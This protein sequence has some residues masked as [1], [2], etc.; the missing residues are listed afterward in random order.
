MTTPT[1]ITQHR[2]VLTQA[3]AEARA[4]WTTRGWNDAV[5]GAFRVDLATYLPDDLLA[6]ADRMSMANS[7]ELRSPF[8]DHRVIEASLAIPPAVK[9][10]GLRL[11]GL[12]KRVYAD[13]LS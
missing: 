2:D 13:V 12:L 3:D 7:L 10:P 4:A 1:A 5:D 9:M 11:K 8:C 6:M